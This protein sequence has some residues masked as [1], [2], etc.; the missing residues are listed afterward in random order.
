VLEFLPIFGIS[1]LT[2]ALAVIEAVG[3]DDVG[4]LVDALHLA[5][6][7]QTP[8]DLAAVDPAKLPY[9]QLCDAPAAPPDASLA[10]LRDEA[11]NGRLVAGHGALPLH[12]LLDAVPEVP[13]SLEVR[14]AALLRDYPDP[15]ERA[16][17]LRNET[18]A[19]LA[20]LVRRS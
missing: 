2:T 16:R 19:F 5:R 14:S 8:S 1:S 10:G 6:A 3:R 18:A 9:L 7:G 20:G 15:R 17:H 4:V 13:L 11:L 12:E